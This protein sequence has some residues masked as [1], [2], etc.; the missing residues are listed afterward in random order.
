[1]QRLRHCGWMWFDE[2]E[3]EVSHMLWSS[4]SKV[5]AQLNA[6]GGFWNIVSDSTLQNHQKKQQ[7]EGVSFVSTAFMSEHWNCSGTQMLNF[8]LISHPASVKVSKKTSFIFMKMSLLAFLLTLLSVGSITLWLTLSLLSFP[9]L[10]SHIDGH[11]GEGLSLHGLY[12]E[13]GLTL[14][15]KM[16][17]MKWNT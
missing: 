16:L 7:N 14:Q 8:G 4:Q 13:I 3:N 15:C 9:L 10:L 2:D 6:Y 5:S 17:R 1:M 11:S 12:L